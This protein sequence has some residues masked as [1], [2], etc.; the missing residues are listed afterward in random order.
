MAPPKT[1]NISV[2][3]SGI[4]VVVL[5]PRGNVAPIAHSHGEM[6][7]REDSSGIGPRPSG[8]MLYGAGLYGESIRIG[9]SPGS[10]R[11]STVA[12]P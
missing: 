6:F 12:A 11:L 8:R 7:F 3:G 1:M 10:G 9:G 4:T 5:R 2:A